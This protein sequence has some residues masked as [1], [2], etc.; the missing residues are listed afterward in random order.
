MSDPSPRRDPPA[1]G[2]PEQR[3]SARLAAA[4]GELLRARPAL[5]LDE[6]AARLGVHRRTVR[7]ALAGQGLSFRGLR[8]AARREAARAA[9]A[10]W[11][12]ASKKSLAFDLGF[13][14]P[15]PFSRFLRRAG[16]A[17]AVPAPTATARPAQ[18]PPGG[19]GE[20]IA[21]VASKAAAHDVVRGNGAGRISPGG[22]PDAPG[23][24]DG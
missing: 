3:R 8:D 24:A 14:S 23:G 7:R 21:V 5:S 12:P 10:D 6:A 11:P 9:L 22:A 2:A 18:A 13:Q 4:L 17:A 1:T 15:S 20:A 19:I 16:V